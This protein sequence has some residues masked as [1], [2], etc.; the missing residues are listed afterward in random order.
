MVAQ[1]QKVVDISEWR[2]SAAMDMDNFQFQQ[3]TELL[4]KR[5][6]ISLPQGGQ[7]GYRRRQYLHLNTI[8]ELGGV[9]ATVRCGCSKVIV[10]RYY[11]VNHQ[12]PLAYTAAGRTAQVNLAF[13]ETRGIGR[14]YEYLHHAIS[15]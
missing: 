10:I 12:A 4:A 8:S 7:V 5:T 14:R 3:W 2:K 11:A 6:G 1:S 13:T 9:I 15:R